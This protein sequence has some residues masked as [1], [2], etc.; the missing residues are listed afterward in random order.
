MEKQKLY[1]GFSVLSVVF[2]LIVS[3][4]IQESETS[5]TE[6]IQDILT[7]AEN[8]GPVHYE[9][10]GVTS[11]KGTGLPQT[12][13]SITMEVW[14]KT[15]YIKIE[16]TTANTTTKM[17]VHPDA[18]YLYDALQGKYVKMPSSY[19]TSQKSFEELAEE[20]KESTT[21]QELGTE[22]IEGKTTTIIEYSFATEGISTVQKLWIWNEKGIPLKTE[23]TTEMGNI[24]STVIMEYK[25]FVFED[26]PD[27]TFEV[28]E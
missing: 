16:S 19:P 23:T 20:L 17:I 9:I 26:I 2:F 4:C 15:P 13:I 10:I 5:T 3:G 18:V 12:N 27:S 6:S 24:V 28:T 25:N 22:I 14:Q 1:F 11:M 8:I 21:L 7:K